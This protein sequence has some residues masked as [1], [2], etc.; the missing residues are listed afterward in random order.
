M[1]SGDR[2]DG[3]IIDGVEEE[4]KTNQGIVVRNV[5][6]ALNSPSS[7]KAKALSVTFTTTLPEYSQAHSLP[8]SLRLAAPF[9]VLLSTLR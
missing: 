5:D 4:K 6:S 2:Q 3:D 9:S 7:P 8:A 1:H